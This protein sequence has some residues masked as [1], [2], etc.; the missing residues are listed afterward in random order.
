MLISRIELL[1]SQSLKHKSLRPAVLRCVIDATGLE[2]TLATTQCQ[3]GDGIVMKR[4]AAG[5]LGAAPTCRLPQHYVA[6]SVVND[7]S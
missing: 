5:L 6:K 3:A 4:K 7:H 1:H 2:R